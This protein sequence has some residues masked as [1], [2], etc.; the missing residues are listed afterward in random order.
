MVLGALLRIST[1]PEERPETP[2]SLRAAGQRNTGPN[3]CGL[4]AS[5]GRRPKPKTRSFLLSNLEDIIDVIEAGLHGQPSKNEV[6][7]RLSVFKEDASPEDVQ[8]LSRWVGE[9]IGRYGRVL[10]PTSLRKSI[11][12]QEILQSVLDRLT[13]NRQ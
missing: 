9:R 6:M 7:R 8:F 5:V 1:A 12:H 11:D 10:E 13:A 4:A 2:L 3:H